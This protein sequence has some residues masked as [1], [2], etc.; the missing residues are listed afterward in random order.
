MSTQEPVWNWNGEVSDEY[1]LNYWQ[2]SF[3]ETSTNAD[4]YK[5]TLSGGD[6]AV[7]NEDAAVAVTDDN[8]DTLVFNDWRE[9]KVVY[10]DSDVRTHTVWNHYP[11][12]GYDFTRE[13]SGQKYQTTVNNE[14]VTFPEYWGQ[15]IDD[16]PTVVDNLVAQDLDKQA[17][18]LRVIAESINGTQHSYDFCDVEIIGDGATATAFANALTQCGGT[19]AF[20]ADDLT[21]STIMR[22]KNSVLRYATGH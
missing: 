4:G 19:Q 21:D 16:L 8:G 22:R 13:E 18:W 15:F 17:I 5:Q 10:S 11:L 12:D 1:Q 2:D 7:L 6:K 20:T 14:L 3:V 9:T